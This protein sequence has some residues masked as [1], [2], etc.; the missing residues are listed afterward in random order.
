VPTNGRASRLQPLL[1]G[2]RPRL[3]A[4]L[5][6]TSAVT[7]AVAA[8]ALLS[9]LEQRLREDGEST[10]KTALGSS[11]AELVEIG[12]NPATGQLN[13]QELSKAT[14]AL[15]RRSD[16]EVTVLDNQLDVVSTGPGSTSQNVPDYY[17]QARRALTTGA[18]VHTLLGNELIV[19]EPLRMSATGRRYV[20]VLTKRL[21]YVSSAVQ[22]VRKAFF[23]AAGAGLL[24]ALLLGIGL[25][26]TLLH[27]LERLRDATRELERRGPE[28]S[29]LP[30]D[31]GTDEI[32]ELSRAFARMQ[33]QLRRQ[34]SA[35]RAFVATASHELRTPL[36]SLDG[37]LELLEDDLN[38]AQ[39][40]LQDARERAA[41][42]R[43][44]ART[45]SN[46]ASDL[47]D[48][49]RLDAEVELRS[50]PLE[51]GELSRAVAAELELGAAKREVAL[52]V[53]QPVNSCWAQGDPGAVARIV[54]ILLDNAL[55]IVPL[56]SSVD[57]EA[58]VDG[59]WAQIE[60]RDRGPGVPAAEREV[61]FERFQR[62]AATGGYSGFGLGLAIGRELATRMGG[63]L[64]LVSTDVPGEGG[65]CFRLRLLAVHDLGDETPT[66][67]ERRGA[68]LRGA[69]QRGAEL[70]GAE[71]RGA[72]QYEAE[73]YGTER[74][75]VEQHGAERR[76][77]ERR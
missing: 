58:S 14:N 66:G 28:A 59:Q 3:L 62:G 44:Q 36:T 20:V 67:V 38:P 15:R 10:V 27:R 4:A 8:L 60:V 72:E 18:P 75:G 43:E 26:T 5:L 31:R 63:T 77:A 73:Q 52:A 55:R 45:L 57:V 61:I 42:A 9:P 34:E 2:L 49:S 71:R 47:L 7:L 54:R 17:G 53:H 23:E 69:E 65:A 74:R 46:L 32:G 29:P 33:S 76:G 70:R 56:G 22:V 12:V 19:A 6:L 64:E 51:L 39:L 68:E 21:D 13:A 50:E 1:L 11:R 24:I 35:R 48:L 16:A 40:D 41:R 30:Q 37:M 25:T